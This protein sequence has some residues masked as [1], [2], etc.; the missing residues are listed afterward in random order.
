MVEEAVWAVAVWI[1]SRPSTSQRRD[2]FINKQKMA[3]GIES[4]LAHALYLTTL[5]R[6]ANQGNPGLLLGLII[7]TGLSVAL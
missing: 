2:W 5:A 3:Y 4:N 7:S 1:V 6:Q